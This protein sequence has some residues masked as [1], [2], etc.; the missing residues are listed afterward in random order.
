M[1]LSC[2]LFDR[3]ILFELYSIGGEVHRAHDGSVVRLFGTSLDITERKQ[4]WEEREQLS[5][6][7]EAT[8]DLVAR[9]NAQG[10]LELFEPCWT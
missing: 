3:I 10:Q 1:N 7:I 5:R 2:E 8:S 6:I 9:A 4:I